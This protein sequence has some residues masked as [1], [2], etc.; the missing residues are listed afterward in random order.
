MAQRWTETEIP[1]QNGRMAIVTG[2]NSGIGWETARALAQKGVTVIMACRSLEKAN[3]AADQI[4][5]LNPAGQAVGMPLDLGN[6]D[7]V[8]AFADAFRAEYDRLELL[9][10]NAGVMFTPY[11]KTVQGFE[12]QL[13]INHLGHFALTGLLLDRLNGTPGA[14]IVTVSS[15]THRTGAIDFDNLNWE[16]GY[17]PQRAYGRSKLANLLFTYELQR[18]LT[19]AGKNTLSVAAHPGWTTTNLIRHASGNMR[20][21]DRIF[22]QRPQMGA[23]PTLYAATAPDVRGGEYFGPG[24]LGGMRG[25]PK[26]VESNDRSHDEGVARRLWEVSEELTHVMYQL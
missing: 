25:Y 17:D 6:L 10:N 24:S 11:G 26:K 8:R 20:R 4:K 15:N 9:I 2:A 14:R 3:A 21:M 19:A 13:G 5:Q 18:R 22:G 23:L 7:S 1:D 16:Q 12:Q